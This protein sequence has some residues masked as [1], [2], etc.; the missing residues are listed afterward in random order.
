MKTKMSVII[1]LAGLLI[2]GCGG[3]ETVMIDT[4]NDEGKPVMGLDYRDFNQ[5]ASEMV[6]SMI[7]S[8][9]LKKPGGGRYV[10]T[11]ARVT[12]DT[13][14][15]I[16]TDQL[17]AKIEQELMNSGQVV[18]T[19]AVG[20]KGAPDEMIYEMR[21][22]RDSATGDEFKQET[23]A[24]KRTL[25][26]PELSTSGKIIQRNIRYDNNRQQVEY[27]F[28]LRVTDLTTG[29]VFWQNETIIGKRGSNRSVS[30]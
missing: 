5:A 28:Q 6:Q 24:G 29:L 23:L 27:Y 18:M 1:T 2:A 25:I 11:T 8:G 30:W 9:A 19:A 10:M 13:M 7:S 20:G 21:D 14:Q 16:D 26:A 15:R 4:A 17:T 22:I 3:P 12:N